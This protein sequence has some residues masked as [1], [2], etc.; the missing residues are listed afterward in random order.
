MLLLI[1]DGPGLDWKMNG[2]GMV[3]LGARSE[4]CGEKGRD[5]VASVN[6]STVK[7]IIGT[8]RGQCLLIGDAIFDA[9]QVDECCTLLKIENVAG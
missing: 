6:G 7:S 5:N 1:D 4:H 8:I 9:M 2:G 3:N